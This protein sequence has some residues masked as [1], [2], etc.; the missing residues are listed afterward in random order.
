MIV[1]L[2][3]GLFKGLVIGGLLGF[4]V[5]KLGFAAPGAVVAYLGAAV[6]GVLVGL[7][8]GKPIWAKDAKIEAGMKA[9][10]GA[11]LGAGLMWAVRR[12]INVPFPV[13]L[14]ALTG[15][16]TSSGAAH[17]TFGSL[18]LTSYAIVAA[19][20][21]AFYDA[22]NTPSPEGEKAAEGSNA[23]AK[24]KARVAASPKADEL[25]ADETE[26]PPEKRAK[27]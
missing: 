23:A 4:A 2:L 10:V 16:A 9:A 1:R 24:P 12:W 20:L 26:A 17:G 22:D 11:L 14:G 25:D 13:D 19:V 21:G 8:A 5:A 3:F 15:G 27:R 7:V 18:A 6:A